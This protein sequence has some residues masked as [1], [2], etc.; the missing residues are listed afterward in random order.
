V[1][2]RN[3]TRIAREAASAWQPHELPG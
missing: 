1:L 3:F 2:V